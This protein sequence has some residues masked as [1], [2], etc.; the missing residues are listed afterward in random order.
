M[1][2]N[3]RK[4]FRRGIMINKDTHNIKSKEAS[5]FFFFGVLRF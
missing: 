1:E 2:V 5:Q 4:Y 3:L